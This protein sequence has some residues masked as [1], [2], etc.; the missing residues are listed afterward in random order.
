[1][2]K[3]GFNLCFAHLDPAQAVVMPSA[4]LSKAETA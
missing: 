2:A 3:S 1:M 4:K